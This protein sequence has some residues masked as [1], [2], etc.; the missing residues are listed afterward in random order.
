ML[1]SAKQVITLPESAIAFEDGKTYVYIVKGNG[2]EKTYE[3]RAVKTGLSDGLKIEVKSGV[4]TKDLVRG[5]QIV[6]N[7]E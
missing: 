6:D 3:R 7:E 2:E 5:P 4:S 1:A